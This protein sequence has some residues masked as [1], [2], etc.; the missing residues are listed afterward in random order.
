METY[1]AIINVKAEFEEKDGQPGYHVIY[2][3]N[4]EGWIPLDLFE[5][6]LFVYVNQIESLLTM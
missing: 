6:K 3:D 5:N 1:L 4:H 2:Q